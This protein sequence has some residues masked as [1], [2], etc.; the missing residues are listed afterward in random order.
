MTCVNTYYSVGQKLNN[1]TFIVYYLFF[2][3]TD[4]CI[5]VKIKAEIQHII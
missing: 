2:F 4:I 1:A 5:A 3:Y